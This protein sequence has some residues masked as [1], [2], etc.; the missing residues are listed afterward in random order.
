[1]KKVSRTISGKEVTEQKEF[2]PSK[3]SI[4]LIHVVDANKFELVEHVFTS[5]LKLL[6]RI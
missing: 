2:E 3:F 5:H 4:L 6:L 1:M